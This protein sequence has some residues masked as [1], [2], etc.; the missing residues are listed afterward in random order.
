MKIFK[1]LFATFLMIMFFV[2]ACDNNQANGK[3]LTKINKQ[4]KVTRK[5]TI[6]KQE[7]VAVKKVVKVPEKNNKMDAECEKNIKEYEAF[8]KR[9][10]KVTI[11]FKK[12][13]TNKALQEEYTKVTQEYS[14]MYSKLVKISPKCYQY[15]EYKARYD[16]AMA[17]AIGVSK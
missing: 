9:Y 17:I 7:D 4:L 13:P 1:F 12:D 5:L 14:K 10:K 6:I 3:K 11:D 16:A 8:V 2:T 15:P